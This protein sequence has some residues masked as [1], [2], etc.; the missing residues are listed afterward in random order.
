[1]EWMW[2]RKVSLR[3]SL[4]LFLGGIYKHGGPMDLGDGRNSAARLCSSEVLNREIGEI[5]EWGPTEAET[6]CAGDFVSLSL[7]FEIWRFEIGK[8]DCIDYMDGMDVG[9][10]GVAAMQLGIIFGRD[11]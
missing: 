7:K 2:A 8:L 1:M 3:C 5:G 9:A 6:T 4:G 11:L 10:E